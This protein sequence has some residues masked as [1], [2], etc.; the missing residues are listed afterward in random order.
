[1]ETPLTFEQARVLGCLLEKEMATPDYY[2]LTANALLAACNQTTNREPVVSFDERTVEEALTGLRQKGMAA[3]IHL[4]G[5]RVPKFKHLLNEYYPGL[6]RAELALLAGLLLRGPQSVAELRARSDRLHAFSDTA[7]VENS[8]RRLVEYGDGPLAVCLPPGGGRRATTYAQRL[9]GEPPATT[10]A[11]APQP[12]VVPP[13]PDRVASLESA[14]AELQRE[15]ARLRERI[16]QLEER[17]AV[18]PPAGE[19]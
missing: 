17:S 1:M 6:E 7:A 12:T 10:L 9:S 2:P 5:A 14:L 8:L 15:V 13:P 11:A 19:S 4:A 3:M 16:V 18:A